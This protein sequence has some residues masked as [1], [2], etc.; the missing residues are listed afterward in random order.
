MGPF[1]PEVVIGMVAVLVIAGT[2]IVWTRFVSKAPK[3]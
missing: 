2:Y 3:S 1:T